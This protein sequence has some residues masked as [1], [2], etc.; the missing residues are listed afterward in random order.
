MEGFYKKKDVVSLGGGQTV[1]LMYVYDNTHL[2][3]AR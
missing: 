3:R 1:K 2:N